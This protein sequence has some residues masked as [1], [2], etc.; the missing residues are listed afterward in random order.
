MSQ[1]DNASVIGSLMYVLHCTR[2]NIAFTVYKLSKYTCNHSTDHW[3][4]I[5]K[6][7]G[8]QKK[9]KVFWFILQ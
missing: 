1:I 9:N 2:L 7:L 6:V 5:A 4:A 3:K 8:Y